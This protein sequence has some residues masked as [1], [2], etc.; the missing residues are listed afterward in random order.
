[1]EIDYFNETGTGNGPTLEFYSLFSKEIREKP[2]LWYNTSDM[3]LFPLPVNE[4]I[5]VE[6]TKLFTLI[7]FM[8]ARGL[9]DDRLLDLPLNS[10]FWDIVFDRVK[11]E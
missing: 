2:N 3:S 5:K 8:I 4:S 6:Y 10:L 1:M 11:L 9:Y 7:G